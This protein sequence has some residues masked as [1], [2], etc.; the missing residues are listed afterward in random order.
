MGAGNDDG[1][2]VDFLER[3]GIDTTQPREL[4]VNLVFSDQPSA[5]AASREMQTLG[6][7]TKLEPSPAPWPLRWFKKPEWVVTGTIE[8]PTDTFAMAAHRRAL[9]ALASRH[10]GTYDGWG[11]GT[12]G[13]EV[14]SDKLPAD[15]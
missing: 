12:D 15:D 6:F 4:D 1:K 10:G 3:L 14:D 5:E 9:E 7:S 8:S 11:V 2:L 13:L